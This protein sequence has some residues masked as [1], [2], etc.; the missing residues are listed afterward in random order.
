MST[1]HLTAVRLGGRPGMPLLVLGPALGT[2]AQT[3]WAP[4]APELASDFQLV[5]WDLPG[6]G[7]NSMVPDHP[8]TVADLAAG[9]LSLVDGMGEGIHPPTFHYAGCSVGG[10][11]GLQLLLDAPGRVESAT[12]LG[13]GARLG[14]AAGWEDRA[15]TVL[16]SSTEALVPTAA[17]RW[18]SPGFREHHPGRASS[19]LHA[20][21]DTVDEGYAAVCRALAGFDLR[22]RLPEVAVPVL[23]VAGARDVSAP[24]EVV[25]AVAEGVREGRLVVLEDVAHLAPVEAP[26]AVARLVREH[27]LGPTR[28]QLTVAE[29]REVGMQVRREVLGAEHVDRAMADATELTREFQHFITEYAWGGVWNRPVLDRR[30]RSMITLSA[31]IAGGH[32]PELAMHLRAARTNG[33]S[34]AEIREVIIHS[35]IYCGVPSANVAFRIAQE[36]FAD[37]F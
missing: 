31:L 4:L 9:V 20:L 17:E 3:L 35:A 23:A 16:D 37:E 28:D 7:T 29:L 8:I 5:A 15:E 1:V 32:H 30:A 12:L 36:L 11:V 26:E 25:R 2:T 34:V 19:L 18:F 6:H 13:T 24:P 33:L 10:A 21:G 14:N 22:D 27:A